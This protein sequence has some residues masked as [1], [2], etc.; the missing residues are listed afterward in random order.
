MHL[1]ASSLF[2][3]TGCLLGQLFAA[4]G[5][6]LLWVAA[7]LVVEEMTFAGLARLLM[8]CSV[9]RDSRRAHSRL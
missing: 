1:S 9:L 4:L 6:L 8:T 3:L 2:S 5:R 7:A